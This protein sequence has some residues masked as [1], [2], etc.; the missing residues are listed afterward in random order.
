MCYT[1]PFSP[2]ASVSFTNEDN[3]KQ[4][5]RCQ[6]LADGFFINVSSMKLIWGAK[7]R[8]LGRNSSI[9]TVGGSDAP[10]GG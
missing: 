9:Y 1:T 8:P 4:R 7:R 6:C 2:S 3:H 10:D 5:Q